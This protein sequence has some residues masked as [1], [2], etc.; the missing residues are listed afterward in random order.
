MSG[1]T[2][3]S[4][5]VVGGGSWGTTL[6]HLFALNGNDVLLHVRREDHAEEINRQR[7]NARYLPGYAIHERVTATTDLREIALASDYI[8]I[9]VPSS[10]I[11][12]TAFELGNHLRGDHILLSATKGLEADSFKRITEI[13]REETCCKK[14]GALSGPNLARELMDGQP[15][16][17]V[18]ASSYREVVSRGAHLLT[19]KWMRVYGS[20]DVVGVELAGA[21]KNIL[22][23]ASGVATGLGMGDNAKGTLITR[24]LAEISR[25]GVAAGAT[26]LTFK[27]LAGVGDVVATCSSP[28]S[29][30]FRVGLGLAEGRALSE[31]LASMVEVAEGVNTTRVARAYARKLGVEMPITE[32]LYRV[33]NEQASPRDMVHELMTR[34]VIYETDGTPIEPLE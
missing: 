27:G 11:R 8:V 15:A 14:V 5:C 19:S 6:A 2:T 31:V 16:A 18:I 33:L 4:V 17:T 25:L 22:A 10:A 20:A 30:N 9:V 28:L 34:Q 1:N 24:G 12:K 3:Y 29:R 23:I 21:L 7:T 26:P 13:L 32:A